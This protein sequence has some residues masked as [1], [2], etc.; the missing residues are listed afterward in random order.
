MSSSQFAVWPAFKAAIDADC[1]AEGMNADN[2][3]WSQARLHIIS[4]VDRHF[5]HSRDGDDQELHDIWY[6]FIATC[7]IIDADHPAQDRL[8]AQLLFARNVLEGLSSHG[9]AKGDHESSPPRT[10]NSSIAKLTSWTHL[11]D[12]IAQAWRD[13]NIISQRRRNLAGFIARLIALGINTANIDDLGALAVSHLQQHLGSATEI[14]RADDPRRQAL[15]DNIYIAA[16]F[17]KYCGHVLVTREPSQAVRRGWDENLT[18]LQQDSNPRSEDDTAVNDTLQAHAR[19]T[20]SWLKRWATTLHLG[21][22]CW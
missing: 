21:E 16:I 10:H 4:Y 13:E 7:Q 5:D 17:A 14:M 1:S 15:T 9:S 12:D 22:P 19:L 3:F 2:H 11:A 6:R 20:Q 8:I 18:A